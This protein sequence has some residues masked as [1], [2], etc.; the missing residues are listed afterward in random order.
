M[1]NNSTEIV[2]PDQLQ[3]NLEKWYGIS[4]KKWCKTIPTIAIDVAIKW[5]LSIIGSLNGGSHSLILKCIRAQE[6]LVLKLPYPNIENRF[7]A[8]ALKQYSGEG[9]VKLYSY[10]NKMPAMLLEEI[11]PGSPLLRFSDPITSLKILCDLSQRLRRE[12]LNGITYINI[13]KWATNF[14][15]KIEKAGISASTVQQCYKILNYVKHSNTTKLIN[16]DIHYENILASNREPWLAIDPKPAIGEP[17]FEGA[18][19]LLISIGYTNIET[20]IYKVL[21]IITPYFGYDPIRILS[22]SY[23]RAI[24]AI[25]W[26]KYIDEEPNSNIY[27]LRSKAI[28]NVLIETMGN[29]RKI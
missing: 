27:F 19:V 29:Y 12:P 16:Q 6:N 14:F 20:T 8:I 1:I 26:F 23:L 24:H 9:A 13:Y 18:Q 17:A 28:Y 7:E 15:S 11:L 2:I 3:K 4:G 21:D 25:I 10:Q 22:W 5:N